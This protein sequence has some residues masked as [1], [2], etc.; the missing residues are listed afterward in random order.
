MGVTCMKETQTP[1]LVPLRLLVTEL[2]PEQWQQLQH[3]V[4]TEE[5]TLLRV[6]YALKT[7][8]RTLWELLTDTASVT[9]GVRQL[10]DF[11]VVAVSEDSPLKGSFAWSNCNRFFPA[12][13]ART[14][15]I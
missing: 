13:N 4:S 11:S 14:D 5:L 9:E 7:N 10:S 12:A 1:P 15:P 3:T 2:L 6:H 8:G